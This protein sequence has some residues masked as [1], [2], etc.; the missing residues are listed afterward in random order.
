MKE[1]YQGIFMLSLFWRH[2]LKEIGFRDELSL[3]IQYTN[4][5]FLSGLWQ[6]RKS[7]F[8]KRKK[9]EFILKSIYSIIL[10]VLNVDDFR[11]SLKTFI[12]SKQHL[13][14]LF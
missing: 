14:I 6:N 3:R 11:E 10:H 7:T 5:N 4:R 2:P 1:R 12:L 9:K 8:Q 13:M